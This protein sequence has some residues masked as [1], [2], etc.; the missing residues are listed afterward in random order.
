MTGAANAA[1]VGNDRIYIDPGLVHISNDLG[2]RHLAEV[3]EFLRNL[4]ETIDPPVKSTCWLS[5]SS[6]GV[7]Q[8]LRHVVE[9]AILPLLAGLGLSSVFMDV[10]SR[11]NMRT[12]RL[13]QIFENRRVYSDSE[14]E[15]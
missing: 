1:G 10:L 5:N 6:T 14:L 8:R 13:L 2:Q 9:T 7:P 3:C 4:P 15:L 11:E 12:V